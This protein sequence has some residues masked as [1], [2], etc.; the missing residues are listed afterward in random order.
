M[1]AAPSQGFTL[2]F[3]VEPPLPE[4]RRPP[5]APSFATVVARNS[6]VV[7]PQF[8]VKAPSSHLGAPAIFFLKRKFDA[9]RNHFGCGESV[10]GECV[11]AGKELITGGR[12]KEVAPGGGGARIEARDVGRWEGA[13]EKDG[14]EEGEIFQNWNDSPGKMITAMQVVGQGCNEGVGFFKS[15]VDDLVLIKARLERDRFASIEELRNAS[16]GFDGKLQALVARVEGEGGTDVVGVDAAQAKKRKGLGNKPS[17]RRLKS[18]ILSSNIDVVGIAEP[19][20]PFSRATRIMRKLGMSGVLSNGDENGNRIRVLWWQG[21]ELELVRGHEQAA[22]VR[23]RCGN[24]S[25]VVISFVH[26]L[27]V[28]SE[29]RALWAEL[30]GLEVPLDTAWTVCGDINAILDP[31]EKVGGRHVCAV[32]MEEFG[33]FVNQVALVDGGYQGNAFTW[34]N[35]QEGGG[36]ILARLDRFFLNDT[37]VN[38]FAYSSVKHLSRECSD[39]ALILLDFKTQASGIIS[40]FKFQQM[41]LSHPD[42][43]ECVRLCWGKQVQGTPLQI[44]YLKLK[45]LQSRLRA[46]NKVVFGNIHQNARAAEDS[47][48]KVEIEPEQNPT[49]ETRRNLLE[50]KK[51]LQEVLLQEEIFWRQKS[52]VQWLKEGESNT[53]FFHTMVNFRRGIGRVDKVK[54]GNGVWVHGQ[55]DV[56]REAARFFVGL[57]MAQNRRRDED[58]LD[59]IPRLVTDADNEML[60]MVPPMEEVRKAVFGLSCDSAPGPNGFTGHFFMAC[61]DIVGEDVGRA[62]RDFFIGG[63]LPRGYT[64]A[65]LV[66][67]PKKEYPEVILDFCP[68]CLCNFANKI[69]AK[70]ISS[71]IALVLPNII[72]EE[73]GAFVQGRCIHDHIA[74]VQ[75]VVQ[76]INRDTRGSN[77]L[78]KL[79]M[80]KA[81]DREEEEFGCFVNNAG[82]LDA[83]YEEEQ[84]AF[85]RGRCIHDNI[86]LGQEVVQDLNRKTRGGNVILKPEMAKAYNRME[87]SFLYLVLERYEVS[88]RQLV[89]RQKSCFI[90]SHKTSEARVRMV[91]STTGFVRRSLPLIY[92]GVPLFTGRVRVSFFDELLGTVRSK[93]VGWQ[94]RLLSAGGHVTLLR[95]VLPSMPIHVIASVDLPRAIINKFFG[96]CADFLWGNSDWGK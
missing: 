61:W 47:V 87:W 9:L 43:M 14:S 26:A 38:S 4:A 75:E 42:F 88:S 23:C 7:A 44:L 62:V 16:R 1:L 73:Q 69:M 15:T 27:C 17:L 60:M 10:C 70:I 18:L 86:A 37:W 91:G 19:K 22:T 82:L 64:S 53:K 3:M 21:V 78:L 54:D 32:S 48:C 83:G 41:W 63:R 33:S 79:D 66:L 5:A 49:E 13:S 68:I 65:N 52:R 30:I 45:S 46:W 93:I 31:S 8:P 67:I 6:T 50:S 20:I 39:H 56:G 11:V 34:S 51:V 80:A 57:F 35:N 25:F 96:I 28:A 55:E 2:G 59:L 72:S 94:G 85:V 84:G 76:D 40:S 90:M 92:L 58:L 12:E 29:R 77:V 95:H 71:R 81:Y 74:L 24:D 36:K 89:N